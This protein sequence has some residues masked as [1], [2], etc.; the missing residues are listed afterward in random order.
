MLLRIRMEK[1]TTFFP[2]DKTNLGKYCAELLPTSFYLG[3]KNLQTCLETAKRLK[4]IR[5]SMTYSIDA[6]VEWP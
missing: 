4:G 3:K 5:K 6:K 1:V 2:L